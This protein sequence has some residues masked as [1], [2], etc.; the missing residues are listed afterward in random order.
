MRSLSFLLSSSLC[1]AGPILDL[2]DK[3]GNTLNAEVIS[4]SEKAVSVKRTKDKKVFKIPLANLDAESVKNLKA[5]TKDMPAALPDFEL[6]FSIEKRRKNDGYYMETQTISGK[7][8][9]KNASREIDSPELNLNILVI[10]EDQRDDD[11]KTIL[12]NQSFT[13]SP[14]KLNEEEVVLK[15]IKTR[16]DSDNKGS[17]NVGGYKYADYI[18]LL[19]DKDGNHVASKSL[20]RT[21]ND[22]LEGNNVLAKKLRAVKTDTKF[23][24]DLVFDDGK[25]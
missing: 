19:T 24:G 20:N 5:K 4:I 23:I 21:M 15:E 8:I 18:I 12:T 22:M 10:G 16:Y 17:G 11:L 7:G 25:K 9:V 1:F 3:K 13:V 2:T 14:M 6:S